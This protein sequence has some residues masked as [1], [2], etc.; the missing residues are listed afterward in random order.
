MKSENLT[1]LKKLKNVPLESY[2]KCYKNKYLF[3]RNKPDVKLANSP[4]STWL[5]T[6]AVKASTSPKVNARSVPLLFNMKSIDSKPHRFPFTAFCRF[7]TWKIRKHSFLA[8]NDRK[9]PRKFW[10]NPNLWTNHFCLL[11]QFSL[12]WSNNVPFYEMKFFNRTWASVTFYR[13]WEVVHQLKLCGSDV[14]LV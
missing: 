7:Y 1:V 8:E 9:W 14:M 13:N 2:V 5:N 4:E 6:L 3:R 11:G 10:L 12:I